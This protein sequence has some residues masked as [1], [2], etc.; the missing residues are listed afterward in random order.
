MSDCF[1]CKLCDKSVKIK[2]IK[3]IINSLYHQAS[4]KSIIPRYYITNP[5]F[6]DVED[7]LKKIC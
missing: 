1:N 5:I 7:I 3:K 4:T 6:L 2:S